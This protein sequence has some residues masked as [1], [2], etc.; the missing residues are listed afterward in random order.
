MPL[1]KT[2]RYKGNDVNIP[3]TAMK[4]KVKFRLTGSTEAA[5]KLIERKEAEDLYGML[6][7][8]PNVNPLWT[9]KKL[10]KAY[11]P[12][13]D[14]SEVIV[15]QV[16]MI[17]QAMQEHP[18]IPKVVMDYLRSK[19]QIQQQVEKDGK[20]IEKLAKQVASP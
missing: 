19:A 15:P 7:P 14:E 5:N 11:E 12:E 17:V 1:K 4:R 10:L 20:D 8:N 16:Q 6:G 3:R 13:E 9:I 2:F 18:E